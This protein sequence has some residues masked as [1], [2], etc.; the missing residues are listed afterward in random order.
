LYRRNQTEWAIWHLLDRGKLTSQSAPPSVVHLIR[1]LI[2]IDRQAGA[3]ARAPDPWGRR[4]AFIDGPPQGRGAE[5]SYALENVVALW[6]GTQFLALGVPQA[7]TVRFLRALKPELD[8]AVRR[9]H[10]DRAARIEAALAR[11]G[12]VAAKLRQSESVPA[13]DHVYVLTAT[14]DAH[15]VLTTATR[16]GRSTLS[17]ICESREDLLD[18]I[19]TYVSQDKRLVVVEIAN[20]VASLAYFLA[21]APVIK[22]GR[23]A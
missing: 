2:D 1:R 14:V 20:A 7:E 9:I 18:F 12:D 15:G 5:N 19:E 10:R 17:N 3:E 16:R 4:F 21:L 11:K 23:A 6:L 13:D 8:Q 22:R